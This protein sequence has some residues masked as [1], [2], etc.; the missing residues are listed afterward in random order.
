MIFKKKEKT[1]KLIE[2]DPDAISEGLPKR[3]LAGNYAK[4]FYWFG[5]FVTAIHIWMLAISPTATYTLYATHLMLGFIMTIVTYC[6]TKRSPK[7]SLPWYDYVLMLLTVLCCAYLIWQKDELI[8][9]VGVKPT[10][11]DVVVALILVLMCLELTRRTC[12][13]VMPIIAIIFILYA[14]YG[15]VLP[16]MLGHREYRWS[17]ILSY[18]LCYDGI[19]S[20]SLNASATMVFLFIVFGAFLQGCGAEKFFM[21]ISMALAGGKRGGPAKV[22]VISS[23]LFGTVSGNGVANVV[24]TGQI[25]IP[26]MRKIGYSSKFSGAVEATASTGGQIMPPILGSAAFVMSA[27]I[28]VPYSRIISASLIPAILYFL[29]V[30]MMIDLEAVKNNLKGLPKE[31]IPSA[32]RVLFTQGHLIAPLVVLVLTLSVF[33]FSAIRAALVGMATCV[34]VSWIKKDTRMGPRK[35][36]DSLSKGA[37]N[38][39]SVVCACATAGLVI[40]VL[41]MT[42]TGLKFAGAIVALAGG[43]LLFAC[44]LTMVAS[45][46]LGMGLP[47]TAAYLICAAVTAPALTQLGVTALQAHMFIFYFACI[48]SITP[49]VAL[50]AYAA[51]GIA[52]TKPMP[53]A[54]TAC[55][56]GIVAFIV[57][58]M[59]IFGP[60]LLWEGAFFEILLVLFTS[61]IGVI[62]LSFGLMGCVFTK[63]LNPVFRVLMICA[64]LCMIE[65]HLVTDLVGFA[66]GG[67]VVVWAKTRGKEFVLKDG[68]TTEVE[69]FEPERTTDNDNG[70]SATTVKEA[71]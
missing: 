23:A 28:A 54:L 1:A 62:F 16:G 12:G 14:K 71:E 69:S 36:L 53:L 29:A 65:T 17:K 38:T 49:P 10:N 34:V 13:N 66:I 41:Q 15:H 19:F 45:I 32:K 64:A 55:K 40:G 60:A 27:L 39:V 33:G 59:F 57:P 20:T 9:R 11:L 52:N 26:M 31:V 18:M 43:N 37:F 58:Y 3:A 51:A 61:V 56:I 44:V 67:A 2:M 47:T 50:A 6:A 21:E 35:I 63:K 68:P 70:S 22:A 46:I 4:V 42:G 48:S 25:T 5:I 24:T 7:A 30:F 8:F